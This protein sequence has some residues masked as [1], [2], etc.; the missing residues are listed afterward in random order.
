MGQDF[1]A[2]TS[3]LMRLAAS[4]ETE[5]QMPFRHPLDTVWKTGSVRWEG[6]SPSPV[7]GI[8]QRPPTALGKGAAST[9]PTTHSW[10]R[11][12][13]SRF[14]LT[15]MHPD[16]THTPSP[17]MLSHFLLFSMALF[18]DAGLFHYAFPSAPKNKALR[19]K[20]VVFFKRKPE[21]Q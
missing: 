5:T 12:A 6:T 2:G 4:A 11:G 10:G 16:F 7:Q 3:S 1:C 8:A 13:R 9:L 14:V 18:Q 20:P 17:R 19:K 21:K 15:G